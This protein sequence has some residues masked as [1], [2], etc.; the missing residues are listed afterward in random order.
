MLSAQPTRKTPRKL[1]QEEA[2]KGAGAPR[3][4]PE[5]MRCRGGRTISTQFPEVVTATTDEPTNHLTIDSD[6]ATRDPTLITKN[7]NLIRGYTNLTG[8]EASGTTREVVNAFVN[9][10]KDNLLW[11]YDKVPRE[12]S[13][14]RRTGTTAPTRSTRPVLGITRSKK[15][16]GTRLD[17]VQRFGFFGEWSNKLLRLFAC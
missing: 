11:L 6:L 15:L 3:L 14:A 4:N 1:P 17:T 2:M 7:T 8:V 13:V 16:A 9:H 10:L 12:I 5:G